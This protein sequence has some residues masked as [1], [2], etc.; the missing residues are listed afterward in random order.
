MTSTELFY[1][2]V[3]MYNTQ[4]SCISLIKCRD[5]GVKVNHVQMIK[6]D[7]GKT[8]PFPSLHKNMSNLDV[9]V[10]V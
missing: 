1:T 5:T 3:T 10:L 2:N 8:L 7:L 9:D 6:T 4:R